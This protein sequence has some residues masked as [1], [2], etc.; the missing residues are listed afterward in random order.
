MRPTNVTVSATGSS[1]WIPVNYAQENF[2]LGITVDVSAGASLSWV[3]Q[4]TSDDIFDSTVTPTAYT[5]PSGLDAGTGDEI[6]NITIPCRA[7][8]LN[9]TISSGTAKMTVVQGR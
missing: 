5:A 7:V 4:L 8:R 6:G 2:N 1:A 9:C 3:V